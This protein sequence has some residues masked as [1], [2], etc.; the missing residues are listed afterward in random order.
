MKNVL[1]A[2]RFDFH[3]PHIDRPTLSPQELVA[4]SDTMRTKA[5][6]ITTIRKQ[7]GV[8][9]SY[10]YRMN[11]ARF[12]RYLYMACKAASQVS[13]YESPMNP[14]VVGLIVW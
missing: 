3:A 14:R 5:Y 4:P 9:R 11:R 13:V 2:M 6:K 1:Q 7:G 12:N 8:L 10:E